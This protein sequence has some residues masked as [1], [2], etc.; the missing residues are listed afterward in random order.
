[1]EIFNR[2]ILSNFV[3]GAFKGL[4][5]GL[6]L[7][8][9]FIGG[10]IKQRKNNFFVQLIRKKYAQKVANDLNIKL[11]HRYHK[12]IIVSY[13]IHASPPTMGDFLTVA[14]LAR[15]FCKQGINVHFYLIDSEPNK[16]WEILDSTEKKE[17]FDFMENVVRIFLSSTSYQYKQLSWKKFNKILKENSCAVKEKR[18]L[19]LQ[20]EKVF[21]RKPIYSDAFNVLNFLTSKNSEEFLI[22]LL[23]DTEDFSKYSIIEKFISTGFV[24][25]H[26]RYNLKWGTNRNLSPEQVQQFL[27]RIEKENPGKKIII[28]SDKKGADH[29]KNMPILIS[30][31][32]LFSKDFADNFFNDSWLILKSDG[33][34]QYRGGG[35]AMIA[36]F[37]KIKYQITDSCTNEIFWKYPSF[38]SWAYMFEQRRFMSLEELED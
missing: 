23:L 3:V 31:N 4:Y 7:N 37:S 27:I 20:S 14:M 13:D 11:A 2:H 29:Y 24:T 6:G 33:Y 17:L 32:I 19:V 38:T 26:L 12:T 9:T 8:K 15:Y 18:H 22:E 25:W 5:W 35:I 28:I 30:E 16:K 34:Y 21:R 10:I 1:M 36:I